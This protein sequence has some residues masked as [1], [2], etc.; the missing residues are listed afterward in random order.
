MAKKNE[1]VEVEPGEVD[2]FS[3]A[4]DRMAEFRSTRSG[5]QELIKRGGVTGEEHYKL[6]AGDSVKGYFLG[7]G[8]LETTDQQTGVIRTLPTVRIETESRIGRARVIANYDLKAKLSGVKP[9]ALIWF[10]RGDKE[11]MAGKGGKTVVHYKVIILEDDS[12]R[13]GTKQLTNG[14]QPAA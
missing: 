8:T 11:E 6:E 2:V 3:S 1:L 9:G 4:D 14:Q 7:F 10:E 13:E 12:L 5:A